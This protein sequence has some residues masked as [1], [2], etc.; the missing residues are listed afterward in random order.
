[1]NNQFN[2]DDDDDSTEMHSQCDI[3]L[4]SKRKKNNSPYAYLY[5]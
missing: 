4:I 1:V 3:F 2:D 5:F